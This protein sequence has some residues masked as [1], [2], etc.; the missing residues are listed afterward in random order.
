[1]LIIFKQIKNHQIVIVVAEKAITLQ[2]AMLQHIFQVII[3]NNQR[4]KGSKV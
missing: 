1:M 2:N 3:S 4:F